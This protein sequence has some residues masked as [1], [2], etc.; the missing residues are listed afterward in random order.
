M[1]SQRTIEPN[2]A[3]HQESVTHTPQTFVDD[4][5]ASLNEAACSATVC[6]LHEILRS[7]LMEIRLLMTDV[8]PQLKPKINFYDEVR[9]FEINLIERALLSTKGNQSRA[10]R[11]LKLKP[12]TFNAMLRRYEI[13]ITQLL[14]FSDKQPPPTASISEFN[15]HHPQTSNSL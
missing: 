13:N 5:L 4:E 7:M 2:L 11:L 10:A 14:G 12:Q 3:T 8:T 1:H 15:N 9:R 6:R